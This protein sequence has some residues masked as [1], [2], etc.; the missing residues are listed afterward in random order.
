MRISELLEES[1]I[2]VALKE[3]E[4]KQVIAE[5]VEILHKARKIPSEEVKSEIL[6]ALYERESL[7]STGLG[8][9]V[10]I[11]HAKTDAIEKSLVA[12]GKSADG[13]D[14]EALDGNPVRLFFLV[15]AS[16][17]ATDEY[18]KILAAIASI[19]KSD[20]YRRGLLELKSP[21]EVLALIRKAE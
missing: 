14:F 1:C 16:H 5:L 3:R 11:P 19:L 13:I 17:E 8:Y 7:T 12:F 2:E 21:G 15:I 20:K 6:R 4:K 18:L 9:G 10:A